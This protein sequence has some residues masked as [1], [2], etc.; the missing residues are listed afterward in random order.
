MHRWRSWPALSLLTALVVGLVLAGASTARRTATAFPRFEA[1]HGFDVFFYSVGSVPGAA[2]L[3]QV[4]SVT[5]IRTPVAGAPVCACTHPVNVNDFSVDEVAPGKLDGFVK[6]V[7]GHLP[8]QSDPSQVLASDDLEA[9]GVRLG[10]VLHVPL[11]AT[12]QRGRS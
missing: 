3:P 11:V 7:A 8:D 2:S 12:S 9:D 6:L 10:S 5:H 4:A 1:A